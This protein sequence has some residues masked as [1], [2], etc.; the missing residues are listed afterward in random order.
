MQ[1]AFGIFEG[2]GGKGLAH[3]G[4]LRCAEANGIEFIG[5]AGA[6]AG[7]IVASLVA[8]GYQARDLFDPSKDDGTAIYAVGLKTLLGYTD[9]QEWVRFE[10]AVEAFKE[11]PPKKTAK[12]PKLGTI[13]RGIGFYL[14]HKEVIGRIAKHHGVFDT[15]TLEAYLNE[16]LVA[17]LLKHHPANAAAAGFGGRPDEGKH[18]RVLFKDVP[19]PLK[20]VATDVDR[21]ELVVFDQERTPCFPVADAVAASISLPIVFRP[22]ELWYPGPVDD[23]SQ[24]D[25]VRAID[26]GLLSNFPAWLFDNERTTQGPHVPTLGFRLVETESKARDDVSALATY[27]LGVVDVVLNGDPLL[28]TRAIENLHEIPLKVTFSML[29]FDLD[30]ENKCKLY[31]QGW[32]SALEI[33]GKPSFP[34]QR[35]EFRIVLE[36]I[37]AM[38]RELFSIGDTALLRANVICETAPGVLRVTYT[39]NMDMPEDSDDRLEFRRQSGACSECWET[40]ERLAVDLL[41][42]ATNLR[43][44]MDRYQQALVRKD[45]KSLLC[46]PIFYEDGTVLAVLNIDSPDPDIL[47]SFMA[48]DVGDRD[49][50]Q[51]LVN[52]QIAEIFTRKPL[53]V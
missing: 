15:T 17:G 3:V 45:L 5:V 4:A 52:A 18:R 23:D 10:S 6:S 43:W 44:K 50:F 32:T 16:K 30:H 7:A 24:N 8:C 41:D 51:M 53:E 28:E 20:I 25:F 22:K 35:S 40:G 11:V 29:D 37:V 48:A 19:M 38:F 26:G 13:G 1:H 47:R 34:K 12:W 39:Y 27:L 14:D 21:K 42:A 2:G 46:F 31:N 49:D 33:F 36:D 9:E